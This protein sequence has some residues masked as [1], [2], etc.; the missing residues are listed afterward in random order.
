MNDRRRSIILYGNCQA[1]ALSVIFGSHPAIAERFTVRHL[2]SFDD[3]VNQAPM[4]AP[5]DVQ[6]AAILFEQHDPVRFPHRADLPDDCVTATFPSIDFNLLWPLTR[7]NP[8]NDR[9]NPEIPWGEFFYGDRRIIDD[10]E[11]GLSVDE[12]VERYLAASAEGLPD[13]DRFAN[14]ERG[15][16]IARDAKCDVKM[17]DFIFAN[18]R[19]ICLFWCVN[20]PTMAALLEMSRRL[21]DAIGGAASPLGDIAFDDQ[22][23]TLPQIEP[24]ALF[25]VPVHPAIAAHF[26]LRWYQEMGGRY[27]LNGANLTYAEYFRKMAASAIAARDRLSAGSR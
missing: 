5:E 22:P 1:G 10:V 24:L 12:V 16:L 18:F 23:G 19:E 20:H 27:G 11:R 21:V 7:D 13:P 3:P 4:L 14:L 6:S 15:R 9:S 2:A 25:N 26:N 17:A 8:Y